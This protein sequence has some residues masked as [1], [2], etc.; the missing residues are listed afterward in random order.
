MKIDNPLLLKLTFYDRKKIDKIIKNGG[1]WGK[2]LSY[3]DEKIQVELLKLPEQK[4]VD[5]EKKFKLK[6]L[7]MTNKVTYYIEAQNIYK[8]LLGNHILVDV[9]TGERLELNISY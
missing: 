6:F 7:L 1:F 8:V 5:P 2:E 9:N 3:K 4:L